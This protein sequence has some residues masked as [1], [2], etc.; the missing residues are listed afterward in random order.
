MP[1]SDRDAIPYTP[2]TA[3]ECVKGHRPSGKIIEHQLAWAVHAYRI[4]IGTPNNRFGGLNFVQLLDQ[5]IVQAITGRM[6]TN[7][8]KQ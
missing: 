2:S 1:C 7:I 8:L 6:R 3:P 5:V 4:E